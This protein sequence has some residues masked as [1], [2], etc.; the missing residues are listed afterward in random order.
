MPESK[1]A[2]N[3][4]VFGVIEGYFKAGDSTRGM[5]MINLFADRLDEEI[6]YYRQFKGKDKKLVNLEIRTAKQY[7]QQLIRIVQLNTEDGNNPE[8][9]QQSAIYQRYSQGTAGI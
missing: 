3:Y 6:N 2:Y 1:F 5:E 7:Y 8:K 4:F 9:M